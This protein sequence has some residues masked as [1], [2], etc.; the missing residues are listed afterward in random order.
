[1]NTQFKN[2][3]GVTVVDFSYRIVFSYGGSLGGKGQYLSSVTVIP[4][5]L[6]VYWTFKF[7]SSVAISGIMNAGTKEN[8]LAAMQVDVRYQVDSTVSYIESSGSF[9]IR[10]DGLFENMSN[11]H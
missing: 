5:N 1:L 4:H 8:P 10:G 9:Y 3:Y 11:K 2:L 6:S 7:S